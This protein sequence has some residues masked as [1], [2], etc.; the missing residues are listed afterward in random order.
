MWC[1]KLVNLNT[2]TSAIFGLIYFVIWRVLVWLFP[3]QS[4][5]IEGALIMLF[6]FSLILVTVTV[7]KRSE[8]LSLIAFCWCSIFLPIFTAQFLGIDYI[9]QF[10][11]E[12]NLIWALLVYM[13]VLTFVVP[14]LMIYQGLVFAHASSRI[15]ED[16]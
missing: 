10:V 9:S 4:K 7:L 5:L 15:Q 2:E 1:K 16:S 12:E 14:A 13:V 3:L 8:P 6:A 11:P